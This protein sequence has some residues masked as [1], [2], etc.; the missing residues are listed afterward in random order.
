MARFFNV[1]GPCNPGR[2]YMIDPESRLPKVRRLIEQDAYFV[3]HAPRQ[4][5]KST[6]M[7]ALAA[8]LRREGKVALWANLETTA[9][10]TTIEEVEPILL[11]CIRLHAD[12]IPEPDRPPPI[13]SIAAGPGNRLQEWLAAWTTGLDRPLI[14]FLDEADRVEGHAMVSLLRQLRAGFHFREGGRF[15]VSV[16]LIGMRDLRDYLVAAKDGRPVNTG[17]PFNVSTSI[18]LTNFTPDEI[19]SLYAQHTAETGQTFSPDALDRVVWWT[20]G[21]PYLVNAIAKRCVEDLVPDPAVP[22]EAAHIE[23]AKE[24]LILERVVHLDNLAE[25]MKEDRVARVLA[26]ILLGTAAEQLDPRSDDFRYCV[27]LGLLKPGTAEIA[28][29]WYREVLARLLTGRRLFPAPWWPWEGPDGGLDLPALIDAFRDWWREHAD[30]LYENDDTPYREAAA[31]VAF[32]GFLQRVVNGGGTI[33]REYAAGRG[34]I[35]LLVDFRGER[36]VIEL[37]R[38]APQRATLERVRAEGI[39][40]LTG[41]LDTVGVAEGWLLIFDQR[42]DRT[43]EEKLWSEEVESNGKRLHLR[44]A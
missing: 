19:A 29:P 9:G 39:A 3:L 40:Q 30:F 31:H 11:D 16:A 5:G 7:K 12:L 2:H 24:Q 41:Y 37:K 34:R 21:Q 43:W 15:P 18:T 26:P 28:N 13:S 14:L 10:F 1:L 35:D 27:D 4:T 33:L 42:A 17:S 32:M 6:A 38:V 36:H 44:G 23:I 20:E 22:V 25:R 8:N